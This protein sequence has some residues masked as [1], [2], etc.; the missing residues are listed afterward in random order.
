MTKSDLVTIVGSRKFKLVTIT[1]LLVVAVIISLSVGYLDIPFLNVIKVFFGG[2]SNTESITILEVR[3]PR[4]IIVLLVG[5]ALA[6]SGSILQTVS[7]N[8]LADPGIL[9]I[10]AGAGLGVTLAYMMLPLSGATLYL[11][12]V[13]SFIGAVVM[14]GLVMFFAIEK[15]KGLNPDK[16]IVT[17][18]GTAIAA[19]GLMILL[20]SSMERTDVQFIK[21]WLSGDIWGDKWEFVVIVLPWILIGSIIVFKKRWTLDIMNLDEISTKSVGVDVERERLILIIVAVLL[22]SVSVSVAGAIS[23]VGLIVPHVA[24][25]LFGP[26]HKNYLPGAILLGGLLMVVADFIGRNFFYPQGMPAGIVVAL[27]GAPYFL[28]LVYRKGK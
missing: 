1:I 26:L 23:F 17:G 11:L 6:L 16:L 14:F 12:P 10:N 2:G 5:F 27:I 7:K 18:V 21:N 28:Y 13:F 3:L 22:A 25:L 19:S 15:G 9:G 8:D 4:I 24:R 20:I